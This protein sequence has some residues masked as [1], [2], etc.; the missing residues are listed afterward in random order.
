[1]D[2]ELDVFVD[3]AGTIA[4]HVGHS[5]DR[6]MKAAGEAR[7]Y[8]FLTT[9]R[10][11]TREDLLPGRFDL[12]IAMDLDNLG[13]LRQL[14]HGPADHIRLFGEFLNEKPALNVPDP[15]YG[16]PQ[17][18]ETVLDMLEAGVPRILQSLTAD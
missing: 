2:H 9:A 7:G 6:R 10:Q 4:A 15:Y 17:G 3:S 1:M 5:P 12:V 16:G 8:Q 11:V 18:F 14:A 13:D